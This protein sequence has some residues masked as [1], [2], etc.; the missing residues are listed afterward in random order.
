MTLCWPRHTKRDHH[1]QSFVPRAIPVSNHVLYF[2]P[3]SKKYAKQ[4]S[5]IFPPPR[6]APIKKEPNNLSRTH[7]VS[8]FFLQPWTFLLALFIYIVNG[9]G[10]SPLT[11]EHILIYDSARILNWTSKYC[12]VASLESGF[13]LKQG[14]VDQ[15]IW[16]ILDQEVVSDCNGWDYFLHS[17]GFFPYDNPHQW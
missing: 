12:K 10:F 11:T 13:F 8:D 3:G 17:Y 4:Y 1:G 5:W 14:P 2:F 6:P 16:I 9:H 15:Q 7:S